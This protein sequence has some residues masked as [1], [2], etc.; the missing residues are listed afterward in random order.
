MTPH[1]KRRGWQH[2]KA[3]DLKIPREPNIIEGFNFSLEAIK[4]REKRRQI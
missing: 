4:S 2:V 1:V 3:S